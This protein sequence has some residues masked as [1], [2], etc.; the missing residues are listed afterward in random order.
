[1]P[2]K[3]KPGYKTFVSFGTIKTAEVAVKRGSDHTEQGAAEFDR[4]EDLTSRLTR[5]PKS[6]VDEKRK[7]RA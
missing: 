1:M 2:P 5:V 6:E 7:K 3:A 4:F